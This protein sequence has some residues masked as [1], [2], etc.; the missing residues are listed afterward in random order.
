MHVLNAIRSSLLQE[1]KHTV[2]EFNS[3]VKKA[4][5]PAQLK[6]IQTLSNATS[7]QQHN[8]KTTQNGAG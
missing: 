3:P 1:N 8:A 2:K 6:Q 5:H 7:N 4:D